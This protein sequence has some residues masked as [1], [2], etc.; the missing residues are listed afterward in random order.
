MSARPPLRAVDVSAERGLRRSVALLRAFAVEQTEPDVF[1]ALLASDSVRLVEDFTA[2]AGKTVVDV[3]A[4]PVQFA[5]AFAARG[6]SYVGVDSDEEA[7]VRAG[8]P[9]ASALVAEGERLPLR[10]GSIDVAFSSNVLEHVRHPP[11]LADEMVRVTRPGGLIFLSY[12]NWLS[13][14]GGHET[15]PYHYLGGERAIARY[16]R[17]YGR[18]PKNRVGSNLHRVSVSDGLR[19]ARRQQH[20]ELLDAR[21]RYYP[22]WAKSVVRVPGLREFATWNLLLV[23][24]RR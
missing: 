2:L 19:W 1:Y 9:G 23:L 4:G 18:P 14:W 11:T 21:P 15:S 10:S 22:S 24:R 3:G 20:A 8:V 12:T 7:V 17:R 16:T 5:R 13:P 6:A